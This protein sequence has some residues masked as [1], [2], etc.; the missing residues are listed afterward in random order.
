MRKSAAAKSVL[1]ERIHVLPNS[2]RNR[3]PGTAVAV[4]LPYK[5]LLD[6][7]HQDAYSAHL[8]GVPPAKAIQSMLAVHN[9]SPKFSPLAQPRLTF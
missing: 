6:G 1:S 2:F 3:I 4:Q 5:A 9:A 8:V 7:N